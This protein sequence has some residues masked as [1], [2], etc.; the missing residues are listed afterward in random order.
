MLARLK[1][2]I[3]DVYDTGLTND[4]LSLLYQANSS[5]SMAV[6]TPSGLSDRQTIEDSVLQGDTFGSILA[7]VQA[8]C[9]A[10][11]VEKAGCG[12]KFKNTLPIS[13]LGLVDDRSPR[14]SNEHNYESENGGKTASIRHKQ[15]QNNDYRKKCA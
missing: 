4:S 8:D 10:K 13:M 11:E 9:I 15:M 2:A 12:Y 3:C 7:S 6:N 5:V 14:A 1:K